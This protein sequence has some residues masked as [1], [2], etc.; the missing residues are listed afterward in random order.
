VANAEITYARNT[1]RPSRPLDT[2]AQ[3]YLRPWFGALVERVQ[4]VWRARLNDHVELMR[5]VIT[6]G[7]RAQTYG[8]TIYVAPRMGA[9]DAGSASQ[10]VLLAHELVHVEQYIRAGERLTRFCEV[11]MQ[12]WAQA[13]GVYTHNPL[14]DEAFEKAFAF[15][16]WLGQQVP[17]STVPERLLYRYEGDQ[18]PL[19]ETLIPKRVPLAQAEAQQDGGKNQG[20]PR[21]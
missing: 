5:R 3:F 7:S 6:D 2:T 12:G 16:Q 14:E 4:V 17:V 15:A 11:Y 8:Y 10:L 21:R 13:Q 9:Q 19:R 18:T 20:R 1:Q